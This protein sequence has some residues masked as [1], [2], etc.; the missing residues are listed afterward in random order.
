M[1]QVSFVVLLMTNVM[2]LLIMNQSKV[3]LHLVDVDY[4]LFLLHLSSYHEDYLEL[5]SLVI[6]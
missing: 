6:P 5:N 4:K 3:F 2:V 1:V